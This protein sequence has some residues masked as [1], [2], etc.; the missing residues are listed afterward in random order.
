MSFY[1][2]S[3]TEFL[4]MGGHGVYV[5]ASY[6]ISFACLLG[7]IVYSRS[8]RQNMLKQIHNQQIRQN[9]RQRTN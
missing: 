4:S 1:F 6:G 5:W 7:V 2:E 8:Q 9:Q 3:F